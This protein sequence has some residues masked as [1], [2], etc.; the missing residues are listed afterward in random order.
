VD[1]NFF[2]GDSQPHFANGA[3]GILECAAKARWNNQGPNTVPS[4]LE[5]KEAYLIPR[6]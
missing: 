5:K 6:Y 3:Y 4:Q 1:A 2:L